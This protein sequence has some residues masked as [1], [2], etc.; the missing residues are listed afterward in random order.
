MYIDTHLD[1]MW[2]SQKSGRRF[3]LLSDDGHVDLERARE[4]GLLIG[5]FT[6]FPTESRFATEQM[7][8][9]WI[10]Y[11]LHRSDHITQ[12]TSLNELEA[13]ILHFKQNSPDQRNIGALLHFEGAAGIDPEFNRLYI[14]HQ[15]GLRSMSLTWN[16][17]NQFATG[18]DGP[19]DRGLTLEGRDLLDKMEDL[20]IL[21]DVSHLNDKSFWDIIDHTNGPVFASHS[22]LR[23]Y[24]DHKRNLDLEMV[25]AIANTGGSVG[26]NFCKGFLSLDQESHPANLGCAVSMITRIIEETSIDNVHIGSDFDGCTIPEDMKD[27]RGVENLFEKLRHDLDLSEFDLK[28]IQHGNMLRLIRSHL[29]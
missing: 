28:K 21:I 7:M 3:D 9:N 15:L 2:Q 6:G 20:G 29:T 27:I 23:V 11:F 4:A 17:T 10:E 14:Y 26:V 18:A 22:N 1:T 19:A 24:C 5:F 12:I 8:R 16:E 13:H 25:E